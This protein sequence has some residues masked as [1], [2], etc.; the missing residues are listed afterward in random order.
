MTKR[1]LVVQ[2]SRETG[3]IQE[4]VYAVIQKTLDHMT[5]A[6]GRGEH[7]ELREFGVFDVCISKARVGRNPNQP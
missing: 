1:D 4:D 5:E 7:I 3:L 6:L 2:I